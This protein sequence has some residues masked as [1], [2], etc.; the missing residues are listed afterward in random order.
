VSIEKFD[1]LCKIGQ[2][3]RQPVDLIDD[4]DIDLPRSN[5]LQKLLQCR[6]V[7]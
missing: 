2:R 3:S 6:A 1:A 4:D 7:E 5:L